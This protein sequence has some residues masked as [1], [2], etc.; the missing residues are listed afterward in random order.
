MCHCEITPCELWL[1]PK[2]FIIQ[3]LRPPE[4]H[5]SFKSARVVVLPHLFPCFLPISVECKN[6]SVSKNVHYTIWWHSTWR[7][8]LW[9][10][11]VL[12]NSD[13][14][15]I[16]DFMM[17]QHYTP[18]SYSHV[19]EFSSTV[20]KIKECGYCTVKQIMKLKFMFSIS[21]FRLQCILTVF[22]QI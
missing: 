6:I 12:S 17:L 21:S 8:V 11:Y 5:A 15:L 16:L 13:H 4:S 19:N 14:K 22:T 1:W 10:T 20:A 2:K 18:G 7:F 3:I 9:G